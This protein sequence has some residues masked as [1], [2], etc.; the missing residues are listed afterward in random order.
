MVRLFRNTYFQC[1]QFFSLLLC[2]SNLF[3]NNHKRLLFCLCIPCK[4][5]SLIF[6]FL[7]VI[8]SRGSACTSTGMGAILINI[9]PVKCD[10]TSCNYYNYSGCSSYNYTSCK[11]CC[12]CLQQQLADPS[13]AP[14]KLFFPSKIQS[15]Q[16]WTVKVIQIIKKQKPKQ[17]KNQHTH[18]PPTCCCNMRKKF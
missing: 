7:N 14:H 11:H 2:I 13:T 16:I 8:L 12:Y 1:M 4:L 9:M 5:S 6:Q 17:S 18:T 10:Y 15:S 3:F